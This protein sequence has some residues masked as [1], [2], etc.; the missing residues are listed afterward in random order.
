[1]YYMVKVE[2]PPMRGATPLGTV[3]RLHARAHDGRSL[4]L[5][6]PL[7]TNH[8]NHTRRPQ[9]TPTPCLYQ[10]LRDV[11]N[12]RKDAVDGGPA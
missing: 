11:Q 10:E 1:M 3:G 2:R 8:T 7:H 9:N 5:G 4:L 6:H 12:A